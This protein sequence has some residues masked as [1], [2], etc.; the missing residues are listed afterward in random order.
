M[1][2][3]L[4]LAFFLNHESQAATIKCGV[5]LDSNGYY[6]EASVGNSDVV[7]AAKLAADQILGIES[8]LSND[9]NE[10]GTFLSESRIEVDR[11]NKLIV[12]HL[13]A[14]DSESVISLLS[15]VWSPFER[16]LNAFEQANRTKFAVDVH[17]KKLIEQQKAVPEELMSE[18]TEARDAETINL[19]TFDALYGSYISSRKI[20]EGRMAPER[21]KEK[22]YFGSDGWLNWYQAQNGQI[23]NKISIA[24]P[25]FE[26]LSLEERKSEAANDAYWKSGIA[27]LS[28]QNDVGPALGVVLSGHPSL[29]YIKKI[30]NM[31]SLGRREKLISEIALQKTFLRRI[32]F[33]PALV[34]GLSIV[35]RR[36][37]GSPKFQQYAS[38]VLNVPMTKRLLDIYGGHLENIDE[39][40]GLI[41]KSY[42]G[43]PELGEAKEKA[44]KN[45]VQ[46]FFGKASSGVNGEMLNL[47]ARIIE[48]VDSW[49]AIKK[50]VETKSK[51][52]SAYLVYKNLMDQA[53]AKTKNMPRVS[54]L[55]LPTVTTKYVLVTRAGVT[56]AT[57]GGL[58][59]WMS[60]FNMPWFH[61]I[62]QILP[63]VN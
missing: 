18:L 33:L 42:E 28:F 24:Y 60:T 7:R 25:L 56:L 48:F 62:L 46:M 26:S 14:A 55:Y 5:A 1:F 10:T 54:F 23:A 51:T 39:Y 13:D 17:V 35:L 6:Y 47:G 31:N 16:A 53:E 12:S 30:F 57:T 44:M 27:S 63:F 3:I 58:T 61:K 8:K 40:I 15:S 45:A 50:F 22:F 4:I 29:V 38:G 2:L 59:Y 34:D 36:F 11:R 20:I 49:G 32:N 37:S 43:K 21:L 9:I 19:Q 41:E 52:N